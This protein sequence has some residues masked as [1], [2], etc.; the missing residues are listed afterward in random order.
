[1]KEIILNRLR[2]QLENLPQGKNI[3]VLKGVPLEFVGEE[4]FPEDLERAINNPLN[5]F[6]ELT[7]SERKFLTYEEFLLLNAFIFAQYDNV[8]ILKNNLFMEQFSIETKFTDATKKILLEHFTEPE[9]I[10][11]EPK[12]KN[13]ANVAKLT[14]L[15]V[16]LKDSG[17]FL[18][19]VYN[20]EQIL[21]SPQVTVFNLFDTEEKIPEINVSDAPNF[22]DL[23]EEFDFVEFIHL[24]RL[25]LCPIFFLRLFRIQ[26]ACSL[27][28]RW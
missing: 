15:F 24:I 6:F 20:D 2:C 7:N 26:E 23:Q 25:P 1:M 4:N 12:E 27:K 19:G 16:G 5:Y 13:F 11:D 22:F 3:F 18:I 21:N 17:N 14:E 10:I 8:Y 28:Y 9:N